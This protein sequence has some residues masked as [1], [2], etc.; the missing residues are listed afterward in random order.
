MV[1]GTLHCKPETGN[2]APSLRPQT[3]DDFPQHAVSENSAAVRGA[4]QLCARV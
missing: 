3:R 2:V 1:L 4:S